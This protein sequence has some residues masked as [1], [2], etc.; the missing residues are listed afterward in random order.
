MSAAAR[1]RLTAMRGAPAPKS[2]AVA[3]A[4][5]RL[6][7]AIRRQNVRTVARSANLLRSRL[8]RRNNVTAGYLGVEVKYFDQAYAATTL[9]AP[10]TPDNTLR[11][12]IPTQ[13]CL[14]AVSQG[15]GPSNRDG[16][17]IRMR[18][19]YIKGLVY[20]QGYE[21]QPAPEEPVGAYVAVV[22]DRQT[23]AAQLTPAQVFTNAAGASLSNISLFR[24]LEYND[25]YR[26][27][28]DGT[29]LFN[30]GPQS[31]YA[32]DKISNGGLIRRFEWYIP[33]N[34]DVLFNTTTPT[35]ATVA[36]IVSNSIG[37]I[38]GATSS[39]GNNSL[40]LAYNSRLR[41][42]G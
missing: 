11:A 34:L 15:D 3:A 41:F 2:R 27:L 36:S 20:R 29:F 8:R 31:A 18:S 39:S 42:V 32:L 24:N 38:A 21:D 35:A 16:K 9:S 26:I 7:S 33:L 19:L 40:V 13:L 22:L 30:A 25:R 14:N 12:D 10:T 4:A 28:R 5:A 6:S 37:V 17:K 1:A 23:N